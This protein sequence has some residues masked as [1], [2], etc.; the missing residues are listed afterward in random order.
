MAEREREKAVRRIVV[1]VDGSPPSR[2]AL[3]WAAVIASATGATV[4][5]MITWEFPSSYDD[6][7]Y[8]EYS[9]SW[10]PDLDATRVLEDTLIEV[11]GDDRPAW[12]SS[13]VLEGPARSV[14]LDVST[15]ADM[16]VVGSRGRGGFA[17]LLLGS[18]SAA[19]AEHAKCAVLVA[20]DRPRH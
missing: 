3:E 14:L 16:L 17:G 19:C 11:F 2:A 4:D 5:A 1:G 8:A 6:A 10:R 7:D 9:D 15:S 20:H 12:L 18:V 13:T